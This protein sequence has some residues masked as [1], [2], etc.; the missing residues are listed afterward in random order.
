M[1]TV[2]S[3][4]LKLEKIIKPENETIYSMND[5]LWHLKFVKYFVQEMK[6]FCHWGRPQEAQVAVNKEKGK[7]RTR[8]CSII[9][10]FWYFCVVSCNNNAIFVE[11]SLISLESLGFL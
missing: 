7:Q 2:I 10:S 1:Q 8:F 3:S 9:L 4:L 6:K 11:F 5:H